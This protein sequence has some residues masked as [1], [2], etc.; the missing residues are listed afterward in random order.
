MRYADYDRKVMTEQDLE[1]Y[2]QYFEKDIFDKQKELQ[3]FVDRA[4]ARL[5]TIKEYDKNKQ[6]VIL[7]STHKDGRKKEIM[8]I[9]RYPDG[10]QRDERYS[11]DK[12]AELREKLAELKEKYSGIDWSQF[13]EEI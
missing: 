7:G 13:Y 10:T 6:F 8:L 12:I 9:I 4:N 5:K 1:K 3:E 2:K 11:F